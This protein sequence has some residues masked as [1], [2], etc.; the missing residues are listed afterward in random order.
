[1]LVSVGAVG[2][3]AVVSEQVRSHMC[4][5]ASGISLPRRPANSPLT[6]RRELGAAEAR[7]AGHVAGRRGSEAPR[8]R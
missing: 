7:C 5:C 6:R 2:Y 1:V 8:G 3:V 4:M